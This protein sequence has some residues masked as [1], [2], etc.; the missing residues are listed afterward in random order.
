MDYHTVSIGSP[1]YDMYQYLFCKCLK[2]LPQSKKVDARKHQL[3]VFQI[4]L[5]QFVYRTLVL[6]TQSQLNG[7]VPAGTST[8][9]YP[10]SFAL[11]LA[12]AIPASLSP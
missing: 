4:N 10:K 9:K 12:P 6:M 2:A 5:L 1:F 3:F 11:F 8:M 7:S